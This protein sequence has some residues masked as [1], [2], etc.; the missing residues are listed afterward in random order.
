[1]A[2]VMK[3]FLRPWLP[4]GYS[5]IPTLHTT[6]RCLPRVPM[7]LRPVHKVQRRCRATASCIADDINV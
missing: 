4:H 1:M 6:C 3:C 5:N 7:D 2:A